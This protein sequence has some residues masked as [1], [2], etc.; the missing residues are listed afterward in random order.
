MT[1]APVPARWRGAVG[2]RK[3]PPRLATSTIR[4][5]AHSRR[6]RKPFEILARRLGHVLRKPSRRRQAARRTESVESMI[7]ALAVCNHIDRKDTWLF[8]HAANGTRPRSQ[9]KLRTL[10]IDANVI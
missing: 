8:S 10:E 4:L 2:A 3:Q 5:D 7:E 6:N 1:V 9:H